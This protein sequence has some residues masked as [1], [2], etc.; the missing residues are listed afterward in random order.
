MRGI[1]VGGKN[2]LAMKELSEMFAKAGC[3]NVS[4]YIQS[5]NVIFRAHRALLKALPKLVSTEIAARFGYQVPV[6]V[7]SSEQIAQIIR[8]NPFL[9]TGKPEHMLHVYFLADLPNA[10]AIKSL[11]PDRSPPDAFCVR[12]REVYL[13]LPNGMAR[14]KLSNAYFD[15]KLSTTSTARNWA[16]VLKLSEMLQA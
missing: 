7:R 6:I 4:T 1:N 2:R 13:H 12:N 8:D 9:Q 14:T 11:D 15:S 16:T 10:P 5:G 3:T